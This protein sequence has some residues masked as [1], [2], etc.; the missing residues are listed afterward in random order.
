MDLLSGASLAGIAVAIGS[1]FKDMKDPF[2]IK[3]FFA[4]AKGAIDDT[5][6][7]TNQ[8]KDILDSVKDCFQAYQTQLKANTLIKIAGAIALLTGS[9]VVL[10]LIDS[11]KL[12]V[13]IAALTGLF[14]EL[15]SSMAIFT[16][17][18]G[19]V[20]KLLKLQHL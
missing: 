11:A 3:G 4:G 13:A 6:K 1:F 19:D 8:I 5:R 10:S 14:A 9:I 20:K 7:I 15:V 16:R 18:S 17:I 2:G 12:A